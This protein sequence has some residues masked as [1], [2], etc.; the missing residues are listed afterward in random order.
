MRYVTIDP[1]RTAV[2]VIDADNHPSA[3]EAAGLEIGQVDHGVIERDPFTGIGVSICVYEYSLFVPA[4]EQ[5]YF[6]INGK[7]YGGKALL[8]AFDEKGETID[9]TRVPDVFFFG[10]ARAVEMAIAAGQIE[11]PRSATLGWE[12]PQPKPEYFNR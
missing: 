9:L 11:R 1:T 10:S 6:A 3:V 5:K 4:D 7:L 12:W 2:K 8:Y